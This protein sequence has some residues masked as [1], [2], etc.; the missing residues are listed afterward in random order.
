MKIKEL[1]KTVNIAWSPA[2]QYPIYLAAGSAAQQ[3]D[4]SLNSNSTLELYS[5]N[6]SDPSYDLILKASQAS[7]YKYVIKCIQIVIINCF[8]KIVVTNFFLLFFSFRF[9]KLVWSPLGINSAHP[10]G[11][12]AAGC[13]GGHLQVYSASK[14]L[15]GEDA[16]IATQDKHTGQWLFK[17]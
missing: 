12:I 3:I 7:P 8:G 4:T 2:Q 9:H 11:V 13:E 16:L 5:I 6:L 1:Q 15:R 17:Y 10:N 14:L